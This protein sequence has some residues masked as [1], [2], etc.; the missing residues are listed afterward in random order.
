MSAAE[1]F[2]ALWVAEVAGGPELVIVVGDMVLVL[3][4]SA[5]V[6][7]SLSSKLK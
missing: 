2:L 5:L 1:V 3:A 7:F 6:S 4:A